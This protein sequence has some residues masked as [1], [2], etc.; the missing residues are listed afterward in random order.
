MLHRPRPR[1]YEVHIPS[2]GASDNSCQTMMATFNLDS[3]FQLEFPHFY[4][5]ICR[6]LLPFRAEYLWVDCFDLLSRHCQTLKSGSYKSPLW[7][8]ESCNSGFPKESTCTLRNPNPSS[9]V[10]AHCY[11][12]DRG[13]RHLDTGQPHNGVLFKFSNIF[14]SEVDSGHIVWLWR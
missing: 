5:R 6:K 9:S 7:V 3:R 13:Q 8:M 2:L 10:T 1:C 14:S 11:T 4:N 12:A